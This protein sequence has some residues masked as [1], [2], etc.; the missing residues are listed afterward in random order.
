MVNKTIF[1]SFIL[2]LTG[3]FFLVYTIKYII[4]GEIRF[5]SIW[6]KKPHKIKNKPFLYI[7]IAILQ[8]IL[9]SVGIIFGII[10]LIYME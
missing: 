10:L 1:Y 8:F 5:P 7:T 2:I 9:G 6:D 4:K 3:I